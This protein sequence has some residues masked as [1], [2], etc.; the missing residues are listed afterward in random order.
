MR[1]TSQDVV[2]TS[3]RGHR[4]SSSSSTSTGSRIPGP[5]QTSPRSSVQQWLDALDTQAPPPPTPVIPT[6][7]PVSMYSG[8]TTSIPLGYSASQMAAQRV[9]SSRQSQMSR[10]SRLSNT[11]ATVMQGMMDF[12]TQM[13]NNITHLADG[14]RVDAANREDAMRHESLAHEQC[15]QIQANERDRIQRDEA[16]EREKLLKQEAT[17]WRRE[18]ALREERVRADALAREELRVRSQAEADEWNL[19]REKAQAEFK[20]KNIQFR[21]QANNELQHQKLDA[22]MKVQLAQ[23]E[24]ME[25]R[26]IEFQQ[27][28]LREKDITA[29]EME[30]HLLLERQLAEEKRK[31][32][33]LE[34]EAKFRRHE[35]AESRRLASIPEHV[36]SEQRGPSHTGIPQ[37]YTYSVPTPGPTHSYGLLESL[38]RVPE[39]PPKFAQ[40]VVT[41]ALETFPILAPPMLGQLSVV[42][43][44]H[45]APTVPLNLRTIPQARPSVVSSSVVASGVAVSTTACTAPSH[46]VPVANIQPP[47]KTPAGT[48]PTPIATIPTQTSL[49]SAVPPV[50]TTI[51]VS[52][53]VTSV[54]APPVVTTVQATTL[55]VSTFIVPVAT[56]TAAPAAPI[57]VVKQPQQTKPYT[58]QTSWKSYKEYFTRLALCSGW[59]TRG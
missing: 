51:S 27:E 16:L 50:A 43:A 55:S 22:E 3:Q 57:V 42:S 40:P 44:T 48:M 31:T 17:E 2:V 13:S 41:L 29:K 15:H 11:S 34:C 37:L 19:A 10:R 18:A 56:V 23:M 58:G 36:S 8:V 53:A 47:V 52:P 21:I 30:V 9:H 5:P 7:Q 20:A 35:L 54:S 49:V 39:T 59:T 45:T 24:M 33:R 38:P 32:L 25:R 28:K 12:S 4:R 6:S 46:M 14:I 26:E 1:H